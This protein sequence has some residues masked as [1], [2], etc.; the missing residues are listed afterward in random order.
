MWN[1]CLTSNKEEAEEH[2][3]SPD[4]KEKEPLLNQWL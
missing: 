1:W 4:D 3:D 2:D